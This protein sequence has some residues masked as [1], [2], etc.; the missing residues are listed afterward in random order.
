[1]Y[2]ITKCNH[3]ETTYMDAEWSKLYASFFLISLDVKIND[4]VGNRISK[5]SEIMYSVC[6]S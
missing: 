5:A 4:A 1:M 3:F 6:G 2:A